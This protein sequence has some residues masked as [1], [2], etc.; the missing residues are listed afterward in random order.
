MNNIRY[1]PKSKSDS[2]RTSNYPLEFA[3]FRLLNAKRRCHMHPCGFSRIAYDTPSTGYVFG[4]LAA[5]ALNHP[6]P[7]T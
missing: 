6:R 4:L 2:N 7:S 5:R 1:L 3:L